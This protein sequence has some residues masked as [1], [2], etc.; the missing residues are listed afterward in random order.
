M[1]SSQS[2]LAV[3]L[4]VYTPF[5]FANHQFGKLLNG[6]S[7]SSHTVEKE[8]VEASYLLE[9]TP[10]PGEL[11]AFTNDLVLDVYNYPKS[12]LK[13]N[14]LKSLIEA[15][16]ATGQIGQIVSLIGGSIIGAGTV[17][18]VTFSSLFIAIA[19]GIIAGHVVFPEET[20]A[21]VKEAIQNVRTASKYLVISTVAGGVSFF[22]SG[23]LTD[24]AR[25]QIFSDIL[26]SRVPEAKLVKWFKF[27]K[28][29]SFARVSINDEL[30]CLM[31]AD[32]GFGDFDLLKFLENTKALNSLIGVELF[33]LLPTN[34]SERSSF[35]EDID[36]ALDV[37]F[38]DSFTLQQIVDQHPVF[39][40]N[41]NSSYALRIIE[42]P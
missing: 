23:K 19:T 4:C 38:K 26:K 25:G 16:R 18:V 17:G 28:G 11:D 8:V 37:E 5:A 42:V 15:K 35:P 24:K 13:R 41:V 32:K 21:A 9:H 29:I 3:L 20:Q 12:Q 22:V 10:T 6:S 31:H 39:N 2:L 33:Q 40:I 7:A 30:Y 1:I 27:A 14:Y 34:S 36:T